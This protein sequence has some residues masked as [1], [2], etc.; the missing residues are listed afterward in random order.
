MNIGIIGI[1]ENDFIR[2]VERYTLELIKSMA[3]S[4]KDE[5]IFLFRGKWQSYYEELN[6]FDNVE[7]IT[8]DAL[9]NSKI[10]RHFFIAFS[11]YRFLKK[12]SINLDIIH[13]NNTLPVLF[14]PP[15]PSVM[16]IHDIAEF[17]VPEKYSLIQRIYRKKIAKLSAKNI[18][19]IITVSNFSKKN[20][21]DSLS[22]PEDKVESIYL[23]IDHFLKK[24]EEKTDNTHERAINFRNYILYWSVIEKSKGIIETVKAFELL[25]EDRNYKDLKLLIIGKPGN[26]WKNLVKLISSKDDIIYLGYVNDDILISYIKNAKVILFPSLYEGFGFPALEAYLIN[27]NVITSNTT[28]LGEITKGLTEQVNPTNIYEIS[29]KI[30]EMLKKPQESNYAKKKKLIEKFSWKITAIKT[31]SIYSKLIKQ[32]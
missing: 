8:I 5:K 11:I 23:G 13:Y 6:K 12:T 24:V 3:S 22:I 27:P 32:K 30:K 15:I 18:D 7:L 20:I 29:K 26:A 14:K 4:Y 16:T 21:V 1:T 17:F 19:F 9:K 10:N 2:G 31:F 25:K 28:A